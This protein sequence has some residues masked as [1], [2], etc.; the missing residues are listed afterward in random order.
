MRCIPIAA[1]KRE[2]QKGGNDGDGCTGKK[3]NKHSENLRKAPQPIESHEYTARQTG[4]YCVPRCRIDNGER[5]RLHRARIAVTDWVS[6]RG[7]RTAMEPAKPR[8]WTEEETKLLIE[9][10][11]RKERVP[12]MARGW[13]RTSHRLR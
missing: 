5:G 1:L 3:Q 11:Q 7:A 9:L 4:H 2:K 10:A 12:A 6:I 8:K 13:I